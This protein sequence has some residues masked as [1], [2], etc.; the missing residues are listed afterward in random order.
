MLVFERKQAHFIVPK[1]SQ[2]FKPR[3][4][5]YLSNDDSFSQD[6]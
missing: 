4:R 6:Y 1:L 5:D 3:T 2:H